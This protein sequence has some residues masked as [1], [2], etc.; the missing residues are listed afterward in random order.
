MNPRWKTA[1][2][3]LL[4]LT[5]AAWQTL[6]Q[7]RR[8]RRTAGE[9]GGAGAP[10]QRHALIIGNDAYVR[11][12]LVNAVN[13]A[14]AM[15]RTLRG[16]GFSVE[17]VTDADYPTFDRAVDLFVD[18]LGQDDVAL[19]YYAGHGVQVD[20]E[21]YLI[22]VD[23]D[24]SRVAKVKYR[25]LPANLVRERLEH[26]GARLSILILDAC[27][28]N[29]FHGNRSAGPGL[30]Q[31]ATGIGTFI[32]FSTAPG[33]T[34]AD[35][36]AAGNGLFT[37][38]L[39]RTLETPGLSIDEVFN[40]VRHKVYQDSGGRQIPWTASSL[41]G[42]FT[43]QP[44][45]PVEEELQVAV[46]RRQALGSLEVTVNERGAEVYLDGDHVATSTGAETLRL[47]RIPIGD[48]VVRV[49]KPDY[50]EV[51]RTVRVEPD[52]T[53]R[54]KAWLTPRRGS[55]EPGP[56]LP[57]IAPAP[58]YPAAAGRTEDF[59]ETLEQV[60]MA[61]P[62]QF[63]EIVEPSRSR[64][65][66][67]LEPTVVLP[68]AWY[69]KVYRAASGSFE[70]LSSFEADL[71]ASPGAR[72]DAF[73]SRVESCLPAGAVAWQQRRPSRHQ[74]QVG[75]APGD[76]RLDVAVNGENVDLELAPEAAQ[77]ARL[78]NHPR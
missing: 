11:S 21:N 17:T 78:S 2:P 70:Y 53:A 68:G 50:R 67:F 60:L 48:H 14:H 25:A 64:T 51:V 62:R 57:E 29:P 73:V 47:S 30:A 61:C 31:M 4:L 23:F 22:P 20:G 15:R 72:L 43:F 19:F 66:T 77:A 71:G 16:M 40:Q 28:D 36:P 8:I 13:D 75:L 18:R 46:S 6:A 5:L 12:P 35:S 56:P 54:L 74:L 32:A 33:R 9:T 63:R 55:D 49:V 59:C 76:C 1:F 39:V 45:E 41:I 26:S 65:R 7:D 69:S 24:H 10:A 52:A 42:G 3:T 38:H 34:A 58:A 44:A 37:Q 27:R